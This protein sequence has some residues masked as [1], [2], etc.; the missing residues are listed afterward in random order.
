MKKV[1]IINYGLGNLTSVANAITFLGHEPIISSEK[2]D[3]KSADCLILLGVGAF[4]E[5][6]DIRFASETKYDD[7]EFDEF[8]RVLNSPKIKKTW[9][10]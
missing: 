1:V 3:I 9:W 10:Y 7:F 4:K 5:G 8:G 2:K 6:I